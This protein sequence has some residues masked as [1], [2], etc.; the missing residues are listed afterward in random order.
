MEKVQAGATYGDL[1]YVLQIIW[2]MSQD[3]PLHFGHAGAY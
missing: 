1:T 2:L 3:W